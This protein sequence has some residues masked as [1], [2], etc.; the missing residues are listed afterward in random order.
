MAAK[1]LFVSHSHED[2][3]HVQGMLNLL[4]SNGHEVRNASIDSSRPNDAT[5]ESYIKYSILKP[6]IEWAGTMVVLIGPRTH[7]SHYVNWEIEYAAK[8]GKRIVGVFIQGA[9]ESDLPA[10]FEKYGDSLVGWNSQKL[11]GAIDGSHDDWCVPRPDG[12]EVDRTP[13]WELVRVKNC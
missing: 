12:T 7:E 5:S 4:R 10:A 6:R 13:V 2:D 8:L 1:N 9:K 11:M 3:P